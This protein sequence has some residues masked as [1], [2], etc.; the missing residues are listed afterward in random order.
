MAV[1]TSSGSFESGS[2]TQ[3]QRMEVWVK[4]THE[5]HTNCE[6]NIL[7][8][9]NETR[10]MWGCFPYTL[11]AYMWYRTTNNTHVNGLQNP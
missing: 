9:D 2:I 7:H 1:H 6:I 5:I 8:M 10:S 11:P 4:K 3:E